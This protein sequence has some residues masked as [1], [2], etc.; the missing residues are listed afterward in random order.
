M[1]D[2][3]VV[4]HYEHVSTK[5]FEEVVNAS[6]PLLVMEMTASF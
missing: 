2:E 3:Y 1:I 5:S 4:K 6:K